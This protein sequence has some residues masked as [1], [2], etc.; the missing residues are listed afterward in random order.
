MTTIP[1][2]KARIEALIKQGATEIPL[3]DPSLDISPAELEAEA[4]SAIDE[5]LAEWGD[6]V[7]PGEAEIIRATLLA[8]LRHRFTH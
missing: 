2:A 8:D 4:A 5:A 6:E 3:P 7:A 1:N